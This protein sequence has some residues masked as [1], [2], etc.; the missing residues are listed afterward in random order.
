VIV[1]LGGVI[2]WTTASRWAAM[3]AFY[4][5]TL[6]LAVRHRRAGFVNFAWGDVRLTVTVHDALDGPAREPERI[7]VNLLTDDIAADHGRLVDAGVPVVRPPEPESWGG[8]VA[9]YADPDGNLVQ[10]LELPPG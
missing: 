7:M 3:D 6:G 2:M 5:D 8:R 4:A 1:G 10:L 9:T